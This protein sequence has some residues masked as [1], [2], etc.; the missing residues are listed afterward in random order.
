M[1]SVQMLKKNMQLL[2]EWF[3]RLMLE[4][5]EKLAV[6]VNWTQDPGSLAWAINPLPLQPDNISMF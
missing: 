2:Y 1:Y 5:S 3:K 4:K 6:V